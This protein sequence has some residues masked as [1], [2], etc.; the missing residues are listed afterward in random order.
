MGLDADGKYT[1]L[2]SR[3]LRSLKTLKTSNMREIRIRKKKATTSVDQLLSELDEF[4]A[5]C[6]YEEVHRTVG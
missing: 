5:K 1:V 6:G 3:D 4:L 2:E